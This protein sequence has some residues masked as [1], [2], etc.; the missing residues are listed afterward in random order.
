MS[1][2]TSLTGLNAASADLSVTGN[3]IANVGT[4]GFKKS[5]AEF[6]DVYA[7]N[8]FGIAS[9]AIGS[10]VS[11]TDIRQRFEQGDIEFTDN[12]LDLAIVGQGFFIMSGDQNGNTPMYT[13]AGAFGV[14]KDGYLVTSSNNFL[15]GF[16]VDEKGNA[17]STSLA[18]T[19]SLS[20]PP[21]FG[22]PV[23]SSKVSYGI[24][25][26]ST[27]SSLPI[28]SFDPDNAS[29]YTNATSNTVYD[30]LGNSHVAT[31]YY[32]KV[33]ATGSASGT[34]ENTWETRVYLDGVAMTPSATE[35][36]EFDSAGNLTIPADG[37]I[38]YAAQSL[39]NGAD[40]LT[41][42][43]DYANNTT[44]Y[45]SPFSVSNVTQDGYTTGRLTKLDISDT[46]LITANYSNGKNVPV[47]KLALADFSNPEALKQEGATTWIATVDSGDP[48]PGEAGTG[49]FGDI[50]GGALE[51]SNVE[52]TQELVK[53]ITAQRNF[54]A[55]A[56]AIETNNTI[57]QTIINI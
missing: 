8:A 12:N 26:P 23:A 34:N 50:Q 27:S 56:K 46:G 18:S 38:A 35:T 53:L 2:V 19:V 57:S 14:N 13:R 1:F 22:S 41:L 24:N 5:R 28:A 32:I 33:G 17:T 43:F 55:N 51:A 52:L 44:Q 6:G 49:R 20:V 10:G 15:Q 9:N 54:Q 29:T 7:V 36:M 39:G 3:N 40:D 21:G 37:K 48:I 30:S 4:I 31:T 45:A 25:L 11:T 42:T 16:P 47:G